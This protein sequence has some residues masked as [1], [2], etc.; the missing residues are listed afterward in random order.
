MPA[1]GD[2]HE[3][4]LEIHAGAYLEVVRDREP[5]NQL[6]GCSNYLSAAAVSIHLSE[7]IEVWDGRR[8][9]F[10]DEKQNSLEVVIYIV[11]FA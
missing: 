4:H 2:H 6:V 9:L 7:K 5:L 3:A 11:D 8:H 10:I 1:T